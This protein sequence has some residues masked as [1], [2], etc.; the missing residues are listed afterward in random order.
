MTRL[1]L[2]R[3]AEVDGGAAR[4]ALWA[5]AMLDVV[6]HAAAEWTA[7][8]WR[9][10]DDVRREGT[11]MT[12]WWQDLRL[13]SRTLTRRPGFAVAAVGTLALGLGV[14]VALFSVVDA[15]LLRPLPYPDSERL[16]VLWK[17]DIE[18]GERSRFVDHPDLDAWTAGVPGLQVLGYASSSP[19]LIADG[20]P[21]VVT[22]ARVTGAPLGV[23]GIEPEMGR[24]LARSDDVP[25]GP[26]IAVLSHAFWTSR[27]G[28]RQD[29]I[30]STIDLNGEPWEV[31][32]VAPA[33]F[34]FPGRPD[35]WLPRRHPAEGCT[36]GCNTM[37]AVARVPDDTEITTVRDRLRAVDAT[38]AEGFP[39]AHDDVVTDVQSMHEHEVAEVE[40]ALWVL[41][42]AVG[43]VLLIACANVANLMIVRGAARSGEIA[44]S[45]ALG[46]SR[47]RIAR[48]LLAEAFVLAAV[49][50]LVGTG[51]AMWGIDVLVGMA[52]DGLP[53]MDEVGLDLRALAFVAFLVVLVTTAFG[54]LPARRVAGVSPAAFLHGGARVEGDRQGGW[55]RSL[56]LSG[57]VALSL[58]LLLGAGLLFRTLGEIRSVD[59][60]Y[61]MER[62]ERFRISTPSSRYDTEAA[63]RFFDELEGRLV[64]LPGVEAVGHGFGVP[65]ASGSINAGITVRERPDDEPPSVDVRPS[66]PGYLGTMG[67]T[68]VRGRWIEPD[69]R[70]DR[71]PVAV[72]NEAAAQALFPG[73]TPLGKRIALSVTWGF[74][75]EPD[76]TVVGVVGDIRAREATAPDVPT[77]YVPNAQIGANNLYFTLRTSPGAPSMLTPARDIV[78]DLDPELAITT[79]E[80]LEDAVRR[81]TASTRFYLTLLGVF[82]VLAL[83]LAAVGLYG[84]V[85]YAVSRRV[86]EI[87]IRRA[88]G[89]SS[90]E[91]IGLV[92]RQ[93]MAPALVGVVVGLTV[94]RLG[95]TALAAL[96]YEVEPQDPATL[97]SVTLLLLAVVLGATALPARHAAGI[98]PGEALREE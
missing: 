21:D 52:P 47:A 31:V 69:D 64:D 25:D 83:V 84:V 30:G 8:V 3:R 4:T 88:L 22:A 76:R 40:T 91:V 55:S 27:L 41:M 13:A 63:L 23:F 24:D 26:R 19:T 16:L 81:E 89:A 48:Q 37:I 38:L 60:G 97:A 1:F 59:L 2:E 49:A 80:T 14:V 94:S 96:L 68:L 15:V 11:T 54:L 98:Q 45:L 75:D 29:A 73:D 92:I 57:E 20:R 53:R 6:G 86:R 56:L 93:G 18:S 5:A 10:I 66:S 79:A 78:R 62:V 39:D 61:Q 12:G 74:D 58:V 95:A 35:L 90:S 9:F 71:E 44:V 50:G 17:V 32:G 87:G 34:D 33:G 42:G 65:F 85:A 77:V 7:P 46:A 28:G 67:M 51:L 70:R 72:I 82:S 43:M 36:H